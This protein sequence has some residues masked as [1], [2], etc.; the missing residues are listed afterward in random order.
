MR[1]VLMLPDAP[2]QAAR[3]PYVERAAGFV[4]ENVNE[5]VFQWV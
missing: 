2:L 4:R 1:F 3:H 5:A